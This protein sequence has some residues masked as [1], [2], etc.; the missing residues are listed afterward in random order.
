M[1]IQCH[2]FLFPCS[3]RASHIAATHVTA[4]CLAQEDLVEEELSRTNTEEITN[5]WIY[6]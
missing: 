6:V 1:F 3:T 4:P 5:Q 2:F